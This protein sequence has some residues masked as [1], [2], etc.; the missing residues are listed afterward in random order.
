MSDEVRQKWDTIYGGDGQVGDAS[1]VLAENS[2]LLPARGRA[3]EVACGRGANALLLAQLGLE[4]HAWDISAV[5]IESLQA[6][7]VRQK[8]KIQGKSGDIMQQPPGPNTFDVIVVSHFLERG[9]IPLLRQ[10]LRPQGL[11]FYQTFT[12]TCVSQRGP[13][14][15]EFRLADNELLDLCRGMRVLVYREEGRVGDLER[16]FRDLAL[17]VAQRIEC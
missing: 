3:L 16:G 5:A 8:V 2:H 1:R 12:R 10:A 7:A 17:I 4:T 11:L 9:L 15:P 13:S 6:E 14:N